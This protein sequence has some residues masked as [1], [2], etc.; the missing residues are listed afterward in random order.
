[1]HT[2]TDS[3]FL[4]RCDGAGCRGTAGAVA[5]IVVSDVVEAGGSNGGQLSFFQRIYTIKTYSAY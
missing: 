4:L 2:S 5:A 1:M 3:I